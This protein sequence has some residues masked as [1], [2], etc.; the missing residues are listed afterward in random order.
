LAPGGRVSPSARASS[1]A[2]IASIARMPDF[3][4][5]IA[6]AVGVASNAFDNPL[7]AWLAALVHQ[8]Q[9]RVAT[10]SDV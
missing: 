5:A 1:V 9:G 4:E 8:S 3:K 2:T 6:I 7:G 10:T